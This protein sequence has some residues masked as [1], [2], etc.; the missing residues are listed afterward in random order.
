MVRGFGK[1]SVK[2]MND[3]LQSMRSPLLI[4]EVI[5]SLP[6]ASRKKTVR[7]TELVTSTYAHGTFENTLGTNVSLSNNVLWLALFLVSSCLLRADSRVSENISVEENGIVFFH[8]SIFRCFFDLPFIRC[9]VSG[10]VTWLDVLEYFYRVKRG[11]GRQSSS[12][13]LERDVSLTSLQSTKNM[14]YCA[15]FQLRRRAEVSAVLTS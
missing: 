8:P 1:D 3:T 5:F 9:R 13:F 15:D 14:A 12:N 7:S 4:S 11:R 10:C 6:K 2:S